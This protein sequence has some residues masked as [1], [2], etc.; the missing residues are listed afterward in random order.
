MARTR[1]DVL[2]AQ[3]A[4]IP[5]WEEGRGKDTTGNGGIVRTALRRRSRCPFRASQVQPVSCGSKSIDSRVHSFRL[6]L[7]I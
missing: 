7:T 2:Q 1:Y 5:C 4:R 6:D 3:V